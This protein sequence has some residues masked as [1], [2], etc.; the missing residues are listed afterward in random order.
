MVAVRMREHDGGRRH[1]VNGVKPVGAAVDH[2]AG[3]PA[4][5]KEGAMPA[6][7]A[8]SRLDLAACA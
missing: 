3:A 2:D 8:R 1:R 5:D 6:V 4:L 7:A